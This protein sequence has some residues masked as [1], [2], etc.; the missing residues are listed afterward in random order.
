MRGRT[1]SLA[2]TNTRTHTMLWTISI[3]SS[4][5]DRPISHTLQFPRPLCR[6]RQPISQTILD[7]SFLIVFFRLIDVIRRATS[8]ISFWCMVIFK[9][10]NYIGSRTMPDCCGRCCCS[11]FRCY[12]SSSPSDW[13]SGGGSDGNDLAG[14][15]GNDVHC[16]RPF[17]HR[18]DENA[19][20]TRPMRNSSS[21]SWASD[22]GADCAALFTRNPTGDGT[23]GESDGPN[24][25]RWVHRTDR[26]FNS[27]AKLHI[28]IMKA[29]WCSLRTNT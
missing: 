26:R 3:T 9:R 12:W 23:D 15:H 4:G 6:L 21:A 29:Q 20:Q 24:Q 25:S 10:K 1:H 5:R 8:F 14:G 17:P 13:T 19:R 27:E 2:C 18:R 7:Q 11:T 28:Y 22:D 16:R